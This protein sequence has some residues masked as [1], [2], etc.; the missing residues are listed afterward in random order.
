MVGDPS[1]A[2]QKLVQ[3]EI[4]PGAEGEASIEAEE[5]VNV[6]KGLCVLLVL[7]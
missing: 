4:A 7:C 6:F 5:Q 3:W 1:G 2:W